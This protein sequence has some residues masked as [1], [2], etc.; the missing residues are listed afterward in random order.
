MKSQDKKFTV[1]EHLAELRSR[2]LKCVIAVVVTS[3]ISFVFARQIFAVLTS[4]TSGFDLIYIDMTELL[5]MY[6]KVCFATGIALAM[7]FLVYQVLM[8]VFP[9]LT[10]KEIK[11]ILVVFPWITFMFIGG[12]LFS[13]F[14]LI[15]PAV[16]FLFTFGNEIA[17]PQIRIG[18]YINV[19]TRVLLGTGIVF[20]LPVITT[21]LARMGIITSSW[22]A[23]RRKVALILAFV[24]GAIIT[25]TFD[26]IN[27]SFI[28]LPLIALYEI[29]IWLARLV[30]PK[31]E[32]A[33]VA[34]G[35]PL[36]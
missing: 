4:P 28:A 31:R 2:L 36:E 6:M 13:Y 17:E 34:L 19:V 18:S 1:L 23:R 35:Q 12:I 10:Q 16:K 7:P 29:S 14:F 24:L 15:P 25:P 30:Q 20:E 33:A 27:Q 11:N 26:P 8:F 32:S 5:G 21:F 3:A 9:A 22:L